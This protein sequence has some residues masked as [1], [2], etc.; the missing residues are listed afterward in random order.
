MSA[1]GPPAPFLLLEAQACISL[2]GQLPVHRLRLLE[3]FTIT[4]KPYAG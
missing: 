4:Y 3:H 1:A 2:R